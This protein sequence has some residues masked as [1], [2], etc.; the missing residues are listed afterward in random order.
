MPL[1]PEQLRELRATLR[2][3]AGSWIRRFYRRELLVARTVRGAQIEAVEEF[4][5]EIMHPLLRRV[6]EGLASIDPQSVDIVRDVVPELVILERDIL[7]IV[8]RGSDAVRRLTTERLDTITRS[9]AAFMRTAARE[10]LGIEVE[11]Q[12]QGTKPTDRPILGER[13]EDWYRDHLAGP[14]GRRARA[15]IHTG[16][17]RGLGTDDIVRGLRGTRTSPGILAGQRGVVASMVRSAASAAMAQQRMDSFAEIGLDQWRWLRT[18]D[19]RVCVVCLRN[20]QESPYPVGEGP[21]FPAHPNCRCTPV[22][23][24]GEPE[25]K[26]ASSKGQVDAAIT[27]PQWLDSLSA[28]EQRKVLGVTAAKAYRAGKVTVADLVDDRK[29][30]PRRVADLDLP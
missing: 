27:V 20:E 28:A 23:W 5:R 17:S 3:N 21:P 12:P 11:E 22:P 24:F 8:E 7:R 30:T 10:E 26:R 18:L 25:G 29:L 4:N 13:V 16:L 15:W 2:Q 1:S 6:G 14:T 9:E 19:L